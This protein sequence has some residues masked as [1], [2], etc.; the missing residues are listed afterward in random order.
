MN[1]LK[2]LLT[3]RVPNAD[4]DIFSG[5]VLVVFVERERIGAVVDRIV[6]FE[7]KSL[8][9]LGFPNV[10]VPEKNNFYV[11]TTDIRLRE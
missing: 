3:S 4:K 6:F 2:S 5:K 11:S 7:K 1:G 8:N 10:A 9:K